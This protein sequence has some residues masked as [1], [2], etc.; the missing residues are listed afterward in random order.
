MQ[1]LR[2]AEID[3]FDALKVSRTLKQEVLKFDV[4]V[5][6]APLVK[7]LEPPQDA[8]DD[9]SSL[10]FGEM[11]PLPSERRGQGRS[12]RTCMQPD[13]EERMHGWGEKTP[14]NAG[15]GYWVAAAAQEPLHLMISAP[16]VQFVRQIATAQELENYVYAGAVR[17]YE[18]FLILHDAAGWGP[19]E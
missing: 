1:F 13:A 9:D 5:H 18:V 7:V 2:K 10:V 6:G 12:M 4:S 17:T 8:A 19:K 15:L 14:G 16:G 3:D 11:R